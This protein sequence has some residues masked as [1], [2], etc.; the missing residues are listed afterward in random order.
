M[1][2][3]RRLDG[4]RLRRSGEQ[5]LRLALHRVGIDGQRAHRHGC[6]H[7]EIQ[8]VIA[9]ISQRLVDVAT[10]RIGRDS[11][12]QPAPANRAA[13]VDLDVKRLCGGIW[14]ESP[15][16][17]QANWCRL[18]VIA[19]GRCDLGSEDRT[20]HA[21][22]SGS[23]SQQYMQPRHGYATSRTLQSSFVQKWLEHRHCSVDSSRSKHAV[24]EGAT[25]GDIMGWY[26]WQI[27]GRCAPVLL[28]A[29]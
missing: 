4:C 7:Y 17:D 9:G 10:L 13:N 16:A 19:D 27:R 11:A 5:D 12:Q 3:T 2:L 28:S 6:R 1:P 22:K 25:G 26:A 29:C 20:R 18:I 8:T 14:I 15:A 21:H 24:Q 23:K